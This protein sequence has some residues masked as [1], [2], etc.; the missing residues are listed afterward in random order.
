[1]TALAV[2]LSHSTTQLADFVRRSAELAAIGVAFVAH[3]RT[4]EGDV[5]D[6]TRIRWQA[7]A[8][9]ATRAALALSGLAI[10]AVAALRAGAF[11]PTGPLWIGLSV[12]TAGLLVN[13][14][15]WRRYARLER[16]G[17]DPIVASQRVLFRAKCLVDAGVVASLATSVLAP[18]RPAARAAD[19]AG[20]LVVAAYLLWSA[21]RA[22]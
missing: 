11:R 12:A 22:A 4:A 2:V 17:P 8:R 16:A 6:A 10:L 7:R 3:R 21:A 9:A 5:P 18:G 20:S 13:A 1:V 15:F 19:L 14:G